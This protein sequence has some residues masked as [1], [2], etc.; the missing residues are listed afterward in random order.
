MQ[1]KKLPE[2]ESFTTA[3]ILYKQ[4]CNDTYVKVKISRSKRIDNIA[5]KEIY[6]FSL[7]SF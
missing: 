7:A 2:K 6:P 1:K 4:K 3:R 5:L